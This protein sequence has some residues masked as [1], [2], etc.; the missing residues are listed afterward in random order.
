M[1]TGKYPYYHVN[2][3]HIRALS[4]EETFKGQLLNAV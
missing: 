2:I 1:D 3:R 4:V